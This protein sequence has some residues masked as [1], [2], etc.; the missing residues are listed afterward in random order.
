[1]SSLHWRLSELARRKPSIRKHVEP[2]L[3]KYGSEDE[4]PPSEEPE[5][6]PEDEE[7]L[8]KVWGDLSR[9]W[10]AEDAQDR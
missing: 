7:V 8:D 3:R 10:D 9:K 5:M 4:P 2:L 6:T 1:M